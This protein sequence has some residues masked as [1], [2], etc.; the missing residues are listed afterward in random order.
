MSNPIQLDLPNPCHIW[1]MEDVR[2]DSLKQLLSLYLPMNPAAIPLERSEG[3][4]PFLRD[5]PLYFSISHSADIKLCAIAQQPIGLDI[6]VIRPIIHA[7]RILRRIATDDEV[8]WVHTIPDGFFALWTAKEAYLKGIGSGWRKA[9]KISLLPFLASDDA[10]WVI[11]HFKEARDAIG[12]IAMK[13][14]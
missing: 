3:G 10:E 6:E 8:E 2:G 12:A 9:R 13:R 7:E 14:G 11:R 4:K 1:R 5:H